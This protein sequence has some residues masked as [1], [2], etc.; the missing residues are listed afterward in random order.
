MKKKLLLASITIAISTAIASTPAF[1]GGGKDEITAD[2]SMA[3]NY[4]WRGLTQTNNHAAVQGGL[5]ISDKLGFYV[6]SWGS[7]LGDIKGYEQDLYLG[8]SAETSSFG[9]DVGY[10]YY[11]YPILKL[12]GSSEVYANV[13]FAGITTGANISISEE[14]HNSKTGDVY[15]FASYD[16]ELTDTTSFGLTIGNKTSAELGDQSYTHLQARFAVSNITFY[17]DKLQESKLSLNR[18]NLILSI[19]YSHDLDLLK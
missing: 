16:K 11:V 7:T 1:S 3:S 14:A 5:E 12:A 9:Y 15:A 2:V 10:I 13:S 17:Y 4:V 18:D 6:G 19:S 8:F